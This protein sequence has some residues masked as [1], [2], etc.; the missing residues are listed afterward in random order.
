MNLTAVTAGRK[1]KGS[2]GTLWTGTAGFG[3]RGGGVDAAAR[4]DSLPRCRASL[5]AHRELA[6]YHYIMVP[7]S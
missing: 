4:D 1:D 2:Q 6:E 5:R 3:W 7:F